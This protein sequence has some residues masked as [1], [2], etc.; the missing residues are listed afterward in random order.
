M[1]PCLERSLIVDRPRDEVFR[2][3]ADAGNLE[4]L[5][6]S[7]LRFQILTPRP[8]SMAQGTL[9]DYRLRLFGVP[10]NWRTL[11]SSWEPPDCFVDEQ[12]RGPYRSWV[13]TH[14]FRE[15]AGGTEILD[16]VVYQLPLPWLGPL[17]HRPVGRQLERIFNYRQQVLERIFATPEGP[18]NDADSRRS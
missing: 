15:V 11:I 12:L 6:P 10:F 2:F 14:V 13:H 17:A 18:L 4:T 7:E 5:T 8:I 16:R 9:I 3:F 1:S